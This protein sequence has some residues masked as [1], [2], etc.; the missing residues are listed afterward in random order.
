MYIYIGGDH[1]ASWCLNIPRFDHLYQGWK[2]QGFWTT[3]L[4]FYGF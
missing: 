2:K 1:G 4:G 3:I